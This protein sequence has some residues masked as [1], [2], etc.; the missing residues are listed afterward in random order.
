L[1]P[2]THLSTPKNER[3]SRPGWLAYSGRFTHI[4]GRGHPSAAGRAQDKESSP[5]KDERSTAVPRNQLVSWSAF[6]I[7]YH[8][9]HHH[10][11]H[12]HQSSLVN[13]YYYYF[14]IMYY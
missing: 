7:I 2:T 6:K 4:N 1:Q 14:R 9:H 11:H 8:H 3:L 12:H 10:H 5:V 13:N